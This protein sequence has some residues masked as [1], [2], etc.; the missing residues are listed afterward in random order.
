MDPALFS[1]E[2]VLASN[3]IREIPKPE[4][5]EIYGQPSDEVIQIQQMLN[6]SS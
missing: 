4:E 3:H 5:L 6:L 1:E 2:Y